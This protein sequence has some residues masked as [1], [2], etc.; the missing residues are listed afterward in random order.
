MCEFCSLIPTEAAADGYLKEPFAG[1]FSD[2]A[3]KEAVRQAKNR[4]ESDQKTTVKMAATIKT[5]TKD[6]DGKNVSDN[7]DDKRRQ[8]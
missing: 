5:T 4:H 7:E 3:I 6:D 8:G 1:F 2:A